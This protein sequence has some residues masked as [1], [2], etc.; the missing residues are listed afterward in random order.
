MKL[1]VINSRHLHACKSSVYMIHLMMFVIMSCFNYMEKQVVQHQ[2]DWAQKYAFCLL[3]LIFLKTLAI[4]L[5][6]NWRSIILTK[7]PSH[8]F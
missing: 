4:T 7:G 5:F 8:H 6:W 1:H 2:F 3:L